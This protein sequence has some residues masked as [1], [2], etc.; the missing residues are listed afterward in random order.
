MDNIN[1]FLNACEQLGL[2][3]A[4]LFE[5]DDLFSNKNFVKIVY[6]LHDLYTLY[7]KETGR[8]LRHSFD[9]NYK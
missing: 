6:C 8:K 2:A 3:R 5:P 4:V 7:K 9:S 1:A